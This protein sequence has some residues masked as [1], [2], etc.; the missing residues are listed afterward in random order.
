MTLHVAD[1]G[2]AE[3]QIS[4]AAK[5][6]G[7]APQRI[8]VFKEIHR[9]KKR[10]KTATEIAD[11]IGIP[12]KRVLEEAIK[13]VHKQIVSLTKRDGELAY[14]RDNFY[15]AHREQII[16][17]AVRTK[18]YTPPTEVTA[19]RKIVGRGAPPKASRRRARHVRRTRKRHDIFLSHASEDKNAIAR[20]LYR[21]LKRKRVSVWF[22]E[23]TLRIGDSLRGKIDEGLAHCRYGVVLLSPSFFAKDWPKKELDGMVAR[24]N[25]S[26][27]KVI[28]PVWHRVTKAQ[29]TKFSPML[30]GRLAGNTRDGIPALVRSIKQVLDS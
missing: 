19:P 9:G 30:A 23:G 20:P 17:R 24:E 12:R 16:K 7:R 28:L 10:I 3:H 21:A 27:E 2:T 15:Y 29:V 5:A 25:V 13:F 4:E 22:D 26:G 14:Q 6:L 1:R 11:A 8:A 18:A